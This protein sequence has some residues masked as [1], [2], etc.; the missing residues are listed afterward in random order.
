MRE[1]HDRAAHRGAG[2]A[3]GALTQRNGAALHAAHDAGMT[4]ATASSVPRATASPAP[5]PSH[6]PVYSTYPTPD[7]LSEAF[8]AAELERSLAARRALS[9]AGICTPMALQVRV[10]LVE[11]LG[12]H[13]AVDSAR[14][15][16]YVE[17]LDLEV[18][19]VTDQV[20]A[21]RTVSTLHLGGSP[22]LLPDALLQHTMATLRRSFFL[23][24]DAELTID[25]DPCTIDAARLPRLR[26]M[27]FGGIRI[28]ALDLDPEVQR[29]LRRECPIGHLRSLVRSA[30]DAGFESIDIG[31]VHGL[32]CQ[33]PEGLQRTL[34]QVVVLQPDRISVR[35][36][37]PRP[38]RGAPCDD[39]GLDHLSGD[40]PQPTL[41]R[42]ARAALGAAGYAYVGADRFER[43]VDTKQR[44]AF[45]GMPAAD[46][47]ALGVAAI[48]R[49]GDCVYQNETSLDAWHAALEENRL[50]V[51]RGLVL[52]ADDRLR[53]DV[54]MGL[55]ERGR[56]D[57]D[58]LVARHQI[59]LR[60]AC[61]AELVA[62]APLA[63]DGLLELRGDGIRLT[64]D[65]RHSA[66]LAAR[67]FDRHLRDDPAR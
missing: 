65:G 61:A 33:T 21:C 36:F 63:A 20:G 66:A 52:D 31:L 30:R 67:V 58:E 47:I 4:A 1:R 16:E 17:A 28:G 29:A 32:P 51:A 18:A 62:L 37:S 60:T 64:S 11:L 44:R 19:F 22:T 2:Q 12:D 59:D 24:R 26:A 14:A 7:R 50:P 3:S 25:V 43:T 23:T 27:G 49:V 15:A 35:A 39:A 46:R 6:V 10:P 53:R 34:A 40:S 54:I 45:G 41:P 57:F 13:A 55:V 42:E 38:G 48:G 9:D 5:A 56:V 8:G